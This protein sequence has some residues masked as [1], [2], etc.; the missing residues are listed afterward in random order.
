M[1]ELRFPQYRDYLT[2]RT[3]ANKAIMAFLAGSQIARHTLTLTAGSDLL[4]PQVFP[5]VPHIGR[6]SL[7]TDFAIEVLSEAENHMG[8][9][10][11]PYIFAIHEDFMTSCA[12]ELVFR[13]GLVK[14]SQIKDSR[15]GDM[16]ELF[17]S[18][19][20][21]CFAPASLEVFHLLRLMRNSSIHAG[22]RTSQN[23]ET[24]SQNPTQEAL[25]LWRV[26]TGSSYPN[27]TAGA[28]VVLSHAVTIA[29]LAI[30]KRLARDT[31][32]GLAKALPRDLWADIVVEDALSSIRHL[33]D[34]TRTRRRLVGFA[35]WDYEPLA[36]TEDELI[37]A[38]ALRREATQE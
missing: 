16:H 10:A 34:D 31:N 12:L 32:L 33:G 23:L 11:L 24:R 2:Q 19:V 22:G 3:E 6:F 30:T 28:P 9:M 36:L 18:A 26:I 13:A 8:A 29:G 1:P 7:K 37:R 17:D 15:S 4:L 38:F 25:D 27:L 14:R 21:G 35:R 20:G 5:N